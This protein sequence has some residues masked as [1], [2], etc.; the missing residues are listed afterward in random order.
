MTSHRGTFFVKAVAVVTSGVRLLFEIYQPDFVQEFE[1]T[2]RCE[3]ISRAC[4][5][6]R[7]YIHAHTLTFVNNCTASSLDY[8]TVTGDNKYNGCAALVTLH[9]LA[10]FPLNY[11]RSYFHDP[12]QH[13][14]QRQGRLRG[15]RL[16]WN[17]H[18]LQRGPCSLVDCICNARPARGGNFNLLGD[19]LPLSWLSRV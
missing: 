6:S 9:Y 14:P 12:S 15:L 13:K 4:N 18:S 2:C 7:E 3:N 16:L 11:H 8:A 10:T 1:T 19:F 5:E 17:L